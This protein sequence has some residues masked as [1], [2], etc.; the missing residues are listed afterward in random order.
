MK[1]WRNV[2]IYLYPLAAWNEIYLTESNCHCCS[3]HIIDSK[4]SKGKRHSVGAVIPNAE[5]YYSPNCLAIQITCIYAERW[6][7]NTLLQKVYIL[8]LPSSLTICHMRVRGWTLI[9]VI[10]VESSWYLLCWY[11]QRIAG[12]L[13][14]SVTALGFGLLKK[15]RCVLSITRQGYL[16]RLGKCYSVQLRHT[17]TILMT[18]ANLIFETLVITYLYM[19]KNDWYWSR[20]KLEASLYNPVGC[21]ACP[22]EWPL[23]CKV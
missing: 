16:P 10:C 7:T 20:T 2:F 22:K 18:Q 9:N 15:E 11:C 6:M 21:Q 1:L 19:N 14:L 4:S 8:C 13:T 23:A 3:Y 12:K 17:E 5:G